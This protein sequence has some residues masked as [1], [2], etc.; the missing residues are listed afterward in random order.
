MKRSLLLIV[1]LALASGCAMDRLVDVST[2]RVEA[3]SANTTGLTAANAVEVF[4]DVAGQ[5][6]FVVEGPA[7]D[8]R[9]PDEFEYT[10]HEPGKKPANNTHLSLMVI[11]KDISF[12]STIYGTPKDF[13]PAQQAAALFERALDKRA[14]H[15]KAVERKSGIFP[16]ND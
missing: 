8:P 7:Q 13:P 1:G 16:L 14:V 12:I 5:L 4:G 9:T 15:Y 2:L 3:N 10:A 11:G 6:G